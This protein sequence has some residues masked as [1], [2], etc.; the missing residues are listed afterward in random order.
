MRTGM[1]LQIMKGGVL[2]G[3]PVFFQSRHG[4]VLLTGESLDTAAL[5]HWDLAVAPLHVLHDLLCV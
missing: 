1:P 4:Q 5:F 3:Q 2:A